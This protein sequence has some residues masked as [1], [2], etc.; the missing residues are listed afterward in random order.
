MIFTLRILLF[1]IFVGI[2]GGCKPDPYPKHPDYTVRKPEIK[3]EPSKKNLQKM[4]EQLQGSPYVWAE[5]G[6]DKFD[7]S[8]LTY[9]VYGSMGIELPRTAREQA[10]VGKRVKLSE[11]K[12]GDLLFFATNPRRPHKI[13]HVGIYLGDGWFT[14]ASTVK[15]EV[16]YSNLYQSKYYKKHLR[17]CRRY[18][19]EGEKAP[20]AAP[21]AAAKKA[22]R[23]PTQNEPKPSKR[24][25]VIASRDLDKKLS[26][27]Q[28]GHYYI[29]AG[30]FRGKPNRTYLAKLKSYGYDYRLLTFR[31]EGT[32]INKLL[33]GPYKTK[34]EAHEML[35]AV[36]H[37]INPDAFI[38]EIR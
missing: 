31:K 33:I 32:R 34:R 17:L 36:R 23:T 16:I 3:Y 2:L 30:S 11:L 22:K 15:K 10:K 7:C 25:V 26:H 24:A 20:T 14:H 12:Y 19:P 27:T 29:Q 6:P 4:I 18:L 1:F 5:E 35:D 13:T 38:A 28:A 9:Y 21:W 37:D 8:G